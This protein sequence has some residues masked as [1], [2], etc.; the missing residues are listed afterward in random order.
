M[1]AGESK[2]TTL[3][4]ADFAKLGNAI[5]YVIQQ[6]NGNNFNFINVLEE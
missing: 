1:S 6:V 3:T 4:V 2:K 5:G